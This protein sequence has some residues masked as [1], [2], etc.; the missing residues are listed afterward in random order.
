VGDGPWFVFLFFSR[1]AT[2]PG[3][4]RHIQADADKEQAQ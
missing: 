3:G 2:S 1:L 4:C